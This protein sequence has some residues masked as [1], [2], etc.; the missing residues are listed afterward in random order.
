MF[1]LRH[2]L[3]THSRSVQHSY[4]KRIDS[5]RRTLTR[6]LPT[7]SPLFIFVELAPSL[8]CVH[9]VIQSEP[10]CRG[11]SGGRTVANTVSH[12]SASALF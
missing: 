8:V 10:L 9:R 4:A 12:S 2:R 7:T 3:L 1:V 6:L 5:H 11:G